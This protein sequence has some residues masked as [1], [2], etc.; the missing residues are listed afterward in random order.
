[1]GRERPCEG[2][3]A[4]LDEVSQ[5]S[6]PPAVAM[7]AIVVILPE[8]SMR[9]TQLLPVSE[10]YWLPLASKR[11]KVGALRLME[12]ARPWSPL[13][14]EGPPPAQRVMVGVAGTWEKRSEGKRNMMMAARI[15]A[16]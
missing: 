5:V 9:R 11:M 8:A 1:M 3:G 12:V 15:A 6:L 2:D 16:S 13:K 10:R 7:P 14:T 4:K